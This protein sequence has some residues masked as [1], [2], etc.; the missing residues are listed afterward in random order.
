MKEVVCSADL[1]CQLTDSNVEVSI[2]GRGFKRVW[3]SADVDHVE[4]K[5]SL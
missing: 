4:K 5:Q 3:G 1:V 2:S